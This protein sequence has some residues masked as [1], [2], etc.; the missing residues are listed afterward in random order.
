M[1][2]KK[3]TKNKLKEQFSIVTKNNYTQIMNKKKN[4]VPFINLLGMFYQ[5]CN[6]TQN[7]NK[8]TLCDIYIVGTE[9]KRHMFNFFENRFMQKCS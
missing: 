9:T 1:S 8:S 7:K 2:K 5:I 6:L 3:P 4:V